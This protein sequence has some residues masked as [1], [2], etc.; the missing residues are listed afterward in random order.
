MR[1]ALASLGMPFTGLLGG[2]RREAKEEGGKGESGRGFSSSS[3]FLFS[4][5]PSH[6]V[7][8]WR[9]CRRFP[10]NGFSRQAMEEGTSWTQMVMD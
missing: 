6:R 3:S 5:F 7:R 1:R 4:L 10:A 8:T 2:H 9:G